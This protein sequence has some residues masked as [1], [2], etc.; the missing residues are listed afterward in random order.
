M[1]RLVC[2]EA[3]AENLP[4]VLG[5]GLLRDFHPAGCIDASAASPADVALVL[6]RTHFGVFRTQRRDLWRKLNRRLLARAPIFGDANVQRSRRHDDACR[7]RARRRRH[8]GCASS[9]RSSRFGDRTTHDGCPFGIARWRDRQW[10]PGWRT[11]RQNQCATR[12]Q[13]DPIQ[14]HPGLPM[15][16]D[17][18]DAD[19]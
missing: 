10:L 4:V 19:V 11:C 14:A 18:R 16:Y 13:K 7:W 8:R 2:P 6:A 9:A 5:F 12:K 1:L 3:N 17:S 15:R